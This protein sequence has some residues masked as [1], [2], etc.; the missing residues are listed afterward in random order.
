MF[1]APWI[2]NRFVLCVLLEFNNLNRSNMIVGVQRGNASGLRLNYCCQ[3]TNNM[4]RCSVHIK[5]QYVLHKESNISFWLIKDCNLNHDCNS[6]QKRRQLFLAD[7]NAT[8]YGLLEI[9]HE[10]KYLHDRLSSEKER[11]LKDNSKRA[12]RKA[13]ILFLHRLI[14]YY[15]YR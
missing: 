7:V 6:L 5:L 9:R 15:K 3:G 1:S 8:L 10:L 2:F 13:S 11:T 4:I 12:A 14:P